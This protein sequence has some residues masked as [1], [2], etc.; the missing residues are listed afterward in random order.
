MQRSGVLVL[1]KRDLGFR[2]AADVRLAVVKDELLAGH[3]TGHDAQ[4]GLATSELD[5]RGRRSDADPDRH[6]AKQPGIPACSDFEARPVLH[7]AADRAADD[8]SEDAIDNLARGALGE[9]GSGADT[10][11]EDRPREHPQQVEPQA[12]RI[13]GV[14][15]K[16]GVQQECR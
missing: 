1:D 13:G 4:P 8:S 14:L 11:A 9:A 5:D 15:L 3:T 2:R 10:G 6:E 7:R 12:A 16:P